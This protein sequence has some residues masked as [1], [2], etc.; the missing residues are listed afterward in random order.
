MVRSHAVR[1]VE[2]VA[3][4]LAVSDPVSFQFD[5]RAIK[6]HIA[7]KSPRHCI[8]VADDGKSYKV[9]WMD[10]FARSDA[11]R[12]RVR[13]RNEIA[14]AQFRVGDRVEFSTGRS[15]LQG[16]IVRLSPKR[17]LVV[18]FTG[19]RWRVYYQH[20]AKLSSGIRAR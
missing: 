2:D 15:V 17:A 19:E 11:E 10:V 13:T 12:K 5:G 6:G 16:E 14:K 18:C 7:E 9:P 1:R 20:L 4:E 3:R 8:V